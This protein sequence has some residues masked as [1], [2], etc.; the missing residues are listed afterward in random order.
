MCKMPHIPNISNWYEVYLKINNEMRINAVQQ[1]AVTL[2]PEKRIQNAGPSPSAFSG[3][4]Q[5]DCDV[6]SCV[7]FP[8]LGDG[9]KIHG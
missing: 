3:K 5:T 1:A 6:T 7:I 9:P 2:N 8:A 4:I